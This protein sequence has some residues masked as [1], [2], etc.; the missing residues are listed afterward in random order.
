MFIFVVLQTVMGK[1]T[2]TVGRL[3]GSRRGSIIS[4]KGGKKSDSNLS[5]KGKT[6]NKSEW[7]IISEKSCV[8]V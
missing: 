5:T 3:K 2:L 7:D 4:D 6:K 8:N 1:V